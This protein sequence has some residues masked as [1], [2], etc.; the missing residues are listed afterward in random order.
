[1]SIQTNL[2][3]VQ[4]EQS[5]NNIGATMMSDHFAAKLLAY[6]YVNGGNN[7]M[8]THHEGL[9]AGIAI[10]QQKFNLFGGE[11]PTRH[12]V[13][14][15]NKYVKEL[16]LNGK[17]TVWLFELEDRYKVKLQ[18]YDVIYNTITPRN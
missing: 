1:M 2:L 6:V 4:L 11:I 18:A 17:E 14:L 3:A 5:F 7:E 13:E 16:E 9:G 10:A 15:I 8:I 12:G